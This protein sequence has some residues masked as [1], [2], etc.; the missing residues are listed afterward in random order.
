[1]WKLIQFS[2]LRQKLENVSAGYRRSCIY[3]IPSLLKSRRTVIW[4]RAPDGALRPTLHGIRQKLKWETEGNLFYALS[5]KVGVNG[6]NLDKMNIVIR[7]SR[8][9]VTEPRYW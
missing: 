9:D 3:N 4:F 8:P 6:V 1:M 5:R 2:E 7:Q